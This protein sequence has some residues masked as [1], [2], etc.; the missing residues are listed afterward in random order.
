M[1]TVTLS[2]LLIELLF[3]VALLGVPLAF[4]YSFVL[5]L[6][7]NYALRCCLSWILYA[8][9]YQTRLT[10]L[11]KRLTSPVMVIYLAFSISYKSVN[12]NIFVGLNQM[13]FP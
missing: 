1:V 9:L 8:A 11:C 2:D 5:M 4:F 6:L 3:S 10:F 13:Q 7:D 12:S